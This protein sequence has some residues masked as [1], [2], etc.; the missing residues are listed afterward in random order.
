MFRNVGWIY[1][2]ELTVI[3]S[4]GAA[5]L[6]HLQLVGVLKHRDSNGRTGKESIIGFVGI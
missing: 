2:N 1:L 6:H 3:V 4:N 5:C